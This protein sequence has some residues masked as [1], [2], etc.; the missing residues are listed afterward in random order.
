M[1]RRLR[2]AIVTS[3]PIQYAAP[4]YAHLSRDPELELTVLYCSDFSLRGARDP[5]F[6]RPVAWDIDLLEGYRSVF[7]G[8]RHQTRS[9]AGFWSLVCPELAW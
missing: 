8:A 1:L 2:I 4:L 5:G 9:V 3:H 7:L 6:D